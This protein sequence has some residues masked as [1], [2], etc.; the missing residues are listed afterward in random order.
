MSFEADRQGLYFF[1]CLALGF[2]FGAV[3]FPFDVI[4]QTRRKFL[5]GVFELF[6]ALLFA[7]F[8]IFFKTKY[9]LP[10]VKVYFLFSYYLGFYIYTKTF[11]KIIALFAKKMYNIVR[12]KC[13][14]VKERG[15][16]LRKT[17]KNSFGGNRIVR[18]AAVHFNKRNGLSNDNHKRKKSKNRRARRANKK[19]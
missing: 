13:K 19:A 15:H 7:V 16:D 1:I 10:S 14:R 18:F 3:S 2:V 17:K 5:R 11:A 9:L 6:R 12:T 8:F 4:C